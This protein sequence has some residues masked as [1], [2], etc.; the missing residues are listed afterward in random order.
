MSKYCAVENQSSAIPRPGERF[1]RM[2]ERL[3]SW[4]GSGRSSSALATL[5]MAV[6]APMPIASDR[7]AAAV[8][9][10]VGRRHGRRSGNPVRTSPCRTAHHGPRFSAR[11]P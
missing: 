1:H 2:S 11:Q 9:P 8:N 6:L 4:Y 7:M 3:A 5:K 10:G